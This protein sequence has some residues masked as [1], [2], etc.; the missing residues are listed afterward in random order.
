MNI[1]SANDIKAKIK[2]SQYLRDQNVPI[3][4]NRAVAIWRD[5]KNPSVAFDDNEGVWFDH[6]AGS[7][8]SVIDLY[9]AIEGG[10]PMEAVRVLGDRY[11]LDPV[12]TAR[13][14]KVKTRGEHL[15]EDGYALVQTYTYTDADGKAVYFVDRYEK[16][17]PE[18]NEE[19]KTRVKSFVQRTLTAENLNGV[20]KLLYNLPALRKD[21]RVFVVEGEKDVETLRGLGLTATTNSGGGKYWDNSFNA[22]F[23][24]KDVIILPDNDEIGM[25]HGR[26]IYSM[27]KP[28]AHS[29]RLSVVSAL[30]KGDVTDYIEK[31]GGN[32]ASLLEKIAAATQPE[33]D[34]PEVAKARQANETPLVNYTIE[35]YGGKKGKPI[36]APRLVDDVCADIRERFLN[37]PRLLGSVLFDYHDHKTLNILTKQELRAWVNGTSGHQSDFLPGAQFPSWDEVF[38]RLSQI[39]TRYNGVSA[40]PWFPMRDDIFPTYDALPP[41]DPTHSLF[42]EFLAFFQPATPADRTL[43]AAFFMAPMFYDGHSDRPAWAIDTVDAQ[44]SGKTSIVKACCALYGE[45]Y[46]D[47][48]L[49]SLDGDINQAKKR[50]LSSTGRGK[51]IALFD[52][53]DKTL[54]S[55]NLANFITA[56]AITGMAPYGHGEETR[57]NDITWVFTVNGAEVDTDMATRTYTIHIK[58][59]DSYDPKWPS[60]LNQFIEA[61]RA[62][63]LSDILSMLQNAKPRVRRRSRFGAFDETVLSAACR[64]DEEFAAAD[65]RIS[66]VSEENNTERDQALELVELVRNALVG[67]QKDSGIED[68][69]AI[70]LRSTDIDD[71][72]RR[73]QGALH[74]RKASWARRMIR[75]GLCPQFDRLYDRATGGELR[76][77]FGNLRVFLFF[78]SDAIP[79]SGYIPVQFVTFSAGI[80]KVALDEYLNLRPESERRTMIA[81]NMV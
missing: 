22:E 15:V 7:G 52:N 42:D 33:A 63:I 59:P 53:L 69:K 56:T 35:G 55:G 38:A 29:V 47:M 9:M 11:N 21:Q 24:G 6:V 68:G 20:H 45:T 51:R 4:G 67:Y 57:A 73:S 78:P 64:S 3:R 8:G 50:I 19:G 48:D 54:K 34:R 39:S 74:N 80:P 40:A 49:K 72:L 23:K 17:L 41:A 81:G 58:A 10:S 28:I 37:F 5:G 14:P 43:L 77:Q 2:V 75:A 32:L 70:I 60:R 76:R 27:L 62:Q 65:E 30:P 44:A 1:Y 66:S 31:E 16:E 13:K 79:R 18:P 46:I 25:A 61:N 12:K 71:I 36:Y 26:N